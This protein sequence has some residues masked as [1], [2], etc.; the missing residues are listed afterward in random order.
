MVTVS[1]PDASTLPVYRRSARA[2][3]ISSFG[4]SGYAAADR[5]REQ[6]HFSLGIQETPSWHHINTKHLA[7]CVSI[8]NSVQ[9]SGIS[10][11]IR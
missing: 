1:S 8:G 10:R 7:R 11:P 2:R 6:V 3:F 5:G 9:M 4:G